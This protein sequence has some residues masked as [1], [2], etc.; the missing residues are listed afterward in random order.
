M[1][2]L[3]ILALVLSLVFFTAVVSQ[4]I[5]AATQKSSGNGNNGNNGDNDGG[6]QNQEQVKKEDKD[7]NKE[8]KEQN[9]EQNK[10]DKNLNKEQNKEQ[11]KEDENLNKEQNKE[12]NKEDKN[13][14]KEQ[15]KTQNKAQIKIKTTKNPEINHGISRSYEEIEAS[16]PLLGGLTLSANATFDIQWL[17]KENDENFSAKENNYRAKIDEGI[18]KIVFS[19]IEIDGLPET[20]T[21]VLSIEGG[22]FNEHSPASGANAIG[23]AELFLRAKS[24]TFIEIDGISLE[25]LGLVLEHPMIK[26]QDGKLQFIKID[27]YDQYLAPSRVENK[28]YT[29]FGKVKSAN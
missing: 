8:D 26:I 17:G 10:E 4:P 12:Q 1:R 7:Q 3:S 13:Q 23:N 20:I 27:N 28:Q 25:D 5:F 22:L 15:K 14:N 11:N 6:D 24:M 29:T 9:K 16:L 19:N 2:A 18:I 21:V